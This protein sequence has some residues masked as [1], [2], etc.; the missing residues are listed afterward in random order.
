MIFFSFINVFYIIFIFGSKLI[1]DSIALV[2]RP[3]RLGTTDSEIIL[4][5]I[6][7]LVCIYVRAVSCFVSAISFFP[8][9]INFYLSKVNWPQLW[10]VRSQDFLICL[11]R[12]LCIYRY[13]SKNGEFIF[14]YILFLDSQCRYSFSFFLFVNYFKYF[15]FELIIKNLKEV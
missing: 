2:L 15:W 1:S 12:G 8:S 3:H 7:M 5:R 4:Y 14:N 6:E 11:W 9:Y 13:S 10:P